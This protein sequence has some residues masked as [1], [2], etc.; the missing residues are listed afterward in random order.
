MPKQHYTAVRGR[1]RARDLARHAAPVGPGRPDPR[2]SAT[3]RTVASSPRPRSRGCAAPRGPTVFSARNRFRGVVRSVELDGLLARVEI[4]VTEPA[5][6]VAIITRESAEELA[7][8]AGHERRGRRQGDERDGG[9]VKAR[10]AAS[11][12][13][14]AVARGAGRDRR[15]RVARTGR[16]RR[17]CAPGRPRGRV[18]DRGAAADL[19]RTRRYSFGSS[20]SLAEQIRR[21]APFDVYLSASP[22]YTQALYRERA[23]PQAGRV[24]DE[25]ARHHRPAL[26]PG[27]DQDR[28]R[29]REA[30]E[31]QARRRRAEGA[32]RPLHARGAEAARSAPRAEEDGQPRAGRQGDRRQG[33]ARPGRCRVRLP[34]P[35]SR[36]WPPGCGR[37]GSRRARSRPSSTSSP[38]PA[39]QRIVEAAQDFVISVLGPDGRRQLRAARFGLP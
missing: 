26:E 25:L 27:E 10:L 5:R 7:L 32:D 1:P 12:A 8:A 4:D 16:A 17:G 21:G 22:V 36:R 28:L 24:R 15:A 14:V 31:A 3:R 35:T 34:A 9:A 38:S 18:A 33:R 11:A 2:S 30:A 6:V 13:A 20:N 37:S 23:G 39:S 29:P 19:A